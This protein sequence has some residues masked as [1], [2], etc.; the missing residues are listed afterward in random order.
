M[1]KFNKKDTPTTTSSYEGGKVYEKSVEDSWFNFIFSSYLE[2]TYYESDE[3][4]K[5]RFQELTDKMIKEHGADLVAKAAVFSRDKL[6]MRSI[7]QLTAAILNA[8]KFDNKRAF[9]RNICKRPDDMAEIFA[10]IDAIN[11]KRSHAAVRGF[12]DYLQTLGQYHLAKYKMKGH[13]YNMA[14]IINICHPK[15]T[16]AIQAFKDD[17]LIPPDTWETSISATHG[18]EKKKAQEWQRLVEEGKL[19][20]LALLR[21]LRNILETSPSYGWIRQYLFPAISNRNAI[22]NAKIFPYQI[23]SAYKA[24]GNE[25]A[26]I[27]TAALEEA[28]MY[29]CS[30]VDPMAGKTCIM[31]D[32]SGSMNSPISMRSKITI[33]ECGAVYAAMYI[34]MGND[35]DFIKFG[36]KAEKVDIPT[37][38]NPFALIK[39]LQDNDN[40]G[41]GTQVDAAFRCANEKYD[42]IL[43][44]SDQQCMDHRNSWEWFGE[45]GIEDYKQYCRKYGNTHIYSFDLGNYN[46]QVGNPNN[47]Y[48]HLCTTLSDKVFELMPFIEDSGNLIDY[49][50][51]NCSYV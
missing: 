31:L 10:A 36:T 4:Q 25:Y 11:G 16:P 2:P 20:Y 26:N 27:I 8:E 47:P 19:G 50:N 39:Y 22:V 12:A 5:K 24:L 44:I 30:D 43:L 7:S 23:Y 45:S 21:N 33:R 48:V 1:S 6:G 15:P 42:R 41:Y 13:E 17:T 29:A 28:F 18:D 34:L 40:L 46:T 51:T 32:V 37:W 14:D 49:I 38:M 9:F 35:I 3:V